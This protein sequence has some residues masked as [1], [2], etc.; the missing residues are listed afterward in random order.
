M[1]R[2]SMLFGVLLI[3]LGL[4]G[5]FKPTAFGAVGPEGTSPT[6]LIPAAI[7]A[8][9]L[10]C[11]LAVSANPGFR[12][13][14]MHLAAL[15]GLVGAVGGFMPI[16]RNGMDVSKSGTVAGILMVVACGLFVVMCV[17]SFVLSR[18]ARGEGLP[19]VPRE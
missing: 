7:G 13:A 10:V 11:G 12:K 2:T 15:V 5:Y 6:A 19:D 8:I 14:V 17:R 1:A 3:V 18:I 9:L 4:V 16:V